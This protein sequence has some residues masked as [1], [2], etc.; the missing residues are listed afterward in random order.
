MKKLEHK[1]SHIQGRRQGGGRE[2]RGREEERR[3][4]EKRGIKRERKLNQSFQ[5]QMVMGLFL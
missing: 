4:D 1:I 2:E 3:K 5:E